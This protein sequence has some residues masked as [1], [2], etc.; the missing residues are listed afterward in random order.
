MK[1][2]GIVQCINNKGG[3]GSQRVHCFCERH[4]LMAPQKRKR[5]KREIW[6]EATKGKGEGEKANVAD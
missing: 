5:G 3:V 1:I 2:L 4:S 6:I